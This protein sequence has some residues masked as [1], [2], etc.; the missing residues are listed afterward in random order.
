MQK[1]KFGYFMRILL[2]LSRTKGLYVFANFGDVSHFTLRL[3]CPEKKV[4]AYFRLLWW[5][6]THILCFFL[7]RDLATLNWVRD[8][9]SSSLCLFS[10]C[11]SLLGPLIANTGVSNVRITSFFSPFTREQCP[12]RFQAGFTVN[13]VTSISKLIAVS[14]CRRTCWY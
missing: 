6:K 14:R 7:L 8:F 4:F 13:S 2:I 5:D 3:F 12:A 9:G 1:N 10:L 11:P